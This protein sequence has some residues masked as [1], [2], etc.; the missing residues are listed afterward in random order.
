MYSQKILAITVFVHEMKPFRFL[1]WGQETNNLW[2]LFAVS[3]DR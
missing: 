2:L 3:M 1:F